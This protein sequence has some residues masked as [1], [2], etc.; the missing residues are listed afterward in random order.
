MSIFSPVPIGRISEHIEKAIK[1]AILNGSLKERDKL[2][3]EKGL[4]LQFGVSIVTLREALRSLE[5]IGLI[6]KKKGRGGGIFVS[7]INQQSI[8]TSL[9]TFF[10]FKDL[11]LQHIYEVR[12]ILEPTSARLA[13]E[14]IA[15][16]EIQELEENV[17]T[18]EEILNRAGQEIGEKDFFD[19][20]NRSIDFHRRVVN[21]NR[22]P[23]LSLNVDYVLDY[24]KEYEP[25]LLVPDRNFSA[26]IVKDHRNI[27]NCLR[28]RDGKKCEEEMYLHLKRIGE[29]DENLINP[30]PH[31]ANKLNSCKNFQ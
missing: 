18:C 4:A 7:Q 11:S 20:D 23:I 22:N 6:E 5:V 3:T 28:E 27:L 15:P 2:P 21:S 24:L 26:W 14:R 30:N 9:G 8:K 10:S 1:K 13:A 16:E 19:I 12:M 17:S 25:K 29:Y 31:S